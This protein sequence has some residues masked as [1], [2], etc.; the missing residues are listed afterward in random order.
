MKNHEQ[1]PTEQYANEDTTN[2][3]VGYG[4]VPVKVEGARKESW[5]QVGPVWQSK[6]D[7]DDEILV[8]SSV[9]AQW[10]RKGIPDEIRVLIKRNEG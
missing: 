1:N 10:L 7:D 6:K 9:P 8:I 3:P 4:Y 2:K 5:V